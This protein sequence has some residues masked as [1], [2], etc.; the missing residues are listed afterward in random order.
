MDLWET[1]PGT[2][3]TLVVQDTQLDNRWNKKKTASKPVHATRLAEMRELL[4]A[5]F[6]PLARPFVDFKN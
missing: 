1:S 2:G 6:A 4:K 5:V 3:S